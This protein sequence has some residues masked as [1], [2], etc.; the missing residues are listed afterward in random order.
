[1]CSGTH[2]A[3]GHVEQVLRAAGIKAIGEGSVRY[4]IAVLEPDG[5]RAREI[6]AA[7]VGRDDF[8]ISLYDT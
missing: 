6:L 5:Q 4:D 1:M 2:D 3:S 7:D 8:Q